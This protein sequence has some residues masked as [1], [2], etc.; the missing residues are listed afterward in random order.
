[1]GKG[2][3]IGRQRAYFFII[4]QLSQGLVAW[5]MGGN[6]LTPRGIRL[7]KSTSRKTSKSHIG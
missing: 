6:Y 2:I 1:M 4:F 3:A 7:G 5:F